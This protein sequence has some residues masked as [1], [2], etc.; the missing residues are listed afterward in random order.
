MFPL[1]W[2]LSTVFR[3]GSLTVIDADGGRH[4]IGDGGE[5]RVV[6]RLHERA[7]YRKLV[8]QTE[9][10]AGEG[11]MDGTITFEEGTGVR[12]M[13]GLYLQNRQN[14][15]DFPVFR[16]QAGL[17]RLVRRI[18]QSNRLG[19]ARRNVSH[20]YDIGNDF[21]RLFLD[22]NMLYS[23]AYFRTGDET[24]E[25]AQQNKLRLLAA[26]LD[27]RPGQKVLDIGCG[28]GDLAMYLARLAD[29][30]VTGVTLSSEQ[31]DLANE[32]ARQ[33]GLSDRVTFLLQ[34]YR[35]LEDKFDR[36][37][38][39][40]MFEHVGS[41]HYDEFFRR[42]SEMLSEDGVMMLHSIGRMDVPSFT[43]PWVRKYIF[44]GGY[45][46][47]LSEVLPRVEKN[48]LIVTDVE[49]LRL[50]YARTLQHWYQ[51]FMANREK[52]VE[53]FDERF[54]RMWEFYLLGAEMSFITGSQ[55]VFQMQLSKKR[56][57]L[58][59]TRDYMFEAQ[60]DYLKREAAWKGGSGNAR[61]KRA[62]KAA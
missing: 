48:R 39:V 62:G 2:L 32:R 13:L 60:S 18:Q 6:M 54:A 14:M 26:K 7:L 52:A 51:R 42:I 37:V 44:P 22:E 16:L 61:K 47:S 9:V 38:S 55:M 34:D 23:C 41:Y 46:P 21:Y 3:R 56:D 12:D 53:M 57:T 29:V 59:I 40:G 33:A 5:P 19:E 30:E 1:S 58:P 49:I 24:L 11:Y 50:H 8:T 4:D 17:T 31:C 45:T 27:L 20:H 43:S 25:E 10:A 36:I 35:S 15:G 28:W